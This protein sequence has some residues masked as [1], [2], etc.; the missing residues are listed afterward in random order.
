MKLFQCTEVLSE[1]RVKIS[2]SLI[3]FVPG[4]QNSICTTGLRVKKSS[5]TKVQVWKMMCECKDELHIMVIY[6]F[7]PRQTNKGNK[8][9]DSC[10]LEAVSDGRV[11][12]AFWIVSISG[13]TR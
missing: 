4:C 12:P 8:T 6:N 11:D 1:N 2:Q 9:S 10:R 13:A 5:N 7:I 3:F